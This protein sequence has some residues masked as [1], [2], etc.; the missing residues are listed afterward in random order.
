MD[1]LN[2]DGGEDS[3]GLK[4]HR[5][6]RE[7]GG[8]SIMAMISLTYSCCHGDDFTQQ[9]FTVAPINDLTI[10]PYFLANI[11]FFHGSYLTTIFLDTHT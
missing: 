2:D 7:N 8:L 4:L 3:V 1:D 5:F 11:I 9:K 6:S 10:F